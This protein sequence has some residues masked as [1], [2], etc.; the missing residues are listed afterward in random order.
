MAQFLTTTG[1]SYWLEEIVKSADDRLIL[2]S[3]FLRIN[4]RIKELLEDKNRLKIDIRVVYGKNELQPDENNWLESMTSIRTSFL[5]NLHA[6][7]YVNE[8]Q[9]LLTSMNLYEFSQVNNHEVGIL[10]DREA[11]PQLYDE[12]VQESMRLVRISDEIRVTVARIQPKEKDRKKDSRTAK[13]RKKKGSPKQSADNA[14]C[15]RCKEVV[16]IDP[17]KP[18][19]KRC[20]RIWSRFKN[21]EYEEKYCHLCA[22]EHTTTFAKP[23]CRRCY[24][25]YKNTITF[26][27]G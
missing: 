16:Q 9:V 21:A 15:I 24:K 11:E 1:V 27:G 14:Y 23:A 20:Y 12:I 2:I 10:V 4:S 3:P 18:H 13:K 8:K 22:K 17:S 19:C 7:C 26:P 6:K 25:K 5:Q